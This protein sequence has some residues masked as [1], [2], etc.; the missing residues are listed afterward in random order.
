MF[1]LKF[2]LFFELDRRLLTKKLILK[3]KTNTPTQTQLFTET[4]YF[5]FTNIEKLKRN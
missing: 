4:Q 5:R 2:E 3:S 1:V